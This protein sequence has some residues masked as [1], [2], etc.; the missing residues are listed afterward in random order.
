VDA[1]LDA[2]RGLTAWP[3]M[4][5]LIETSPSS[6]DADRLRRETQ[7]LADTCGSRIARLEVSAL[8]AGTSD[9]GA[10]ARLAALAD[11]AVGLGFAL[12][13]LRLARLAGERLMELG[14]LDA[15]QATLR[16]TLTRA[17]GMGA[18]G[19]A[20]RIHRLLGD[21]PDDHR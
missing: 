17:K 4:I 8:A 1:L 5:A 11:E 3:H 20:R 18:H 10:P 15:A 13:G 9:E 21:D 7:I 6:P 2:G 16:D 14:H 19:E 12:L